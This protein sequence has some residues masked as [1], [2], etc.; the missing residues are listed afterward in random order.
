MQILDRFHALFFPLFFSWL[1]TKHGCCTCF[2][3]QIPDRFHALTGAALEAAQQ[4]DPKGLPT[5]TPQVCIVNFYSGGGS[6]GM[7]QDKDESISTVRRGSPVVSF[8]IG[9]SA[10]FLYGRERLAETASKVTLDSGD[11]LVFGG[12]SRLVFHGVP[13]VLPHSAPQELVAATGLR[14]GRLNLTFR[15]L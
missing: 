3:A 5:M 10:V 9:D 12:P 14:P 15:E 2:G 7:H 6:L 8:S 13:E 4:A 1:S 11:V